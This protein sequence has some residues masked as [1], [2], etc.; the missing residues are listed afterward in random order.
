MKLWGKAFAWVI[1]LLIIGYAIYTFCE[2]VA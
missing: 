1:A 2:V